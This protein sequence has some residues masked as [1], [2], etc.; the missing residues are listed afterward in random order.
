MEVTCVCREILAILSKRPGE[1]E[2][3]TRIWPRLQVQ[4]VSWAKMK[5][6]LVQLTEVNLVTVRERMVAGNR[7]APFY[8]LTAAGSQKLQEIT[9]PKGKKGYA[10]ATSFCGEECCFNQAA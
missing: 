3:N 1:L 6:I 2:L 8:Q 9:K 7:M 5:E 10:N 4:D